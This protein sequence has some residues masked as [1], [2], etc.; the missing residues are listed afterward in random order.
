MH[1]PRR[2]AFSEIHPLLMIPIVLCEDGMIQF[3]AGMAG[4]MTLTCGC[5]W[6]GSVWSLQFVHQARLWVRL[7][8]WPKLKLSCM[9]T[10]RHKGTMWFSSLKWEMNS[11]ILFTVW[12]VSFA[13]KFEIG[14]NTMFNAWP[15][16]RCSCRTDATTWSTSQS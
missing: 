14:S 3:V 8:L 5:H 7:S 12:V 13:R 4:P 1:L 11:Q 16:P 15:F 6:I 9:S 2:T 10:S